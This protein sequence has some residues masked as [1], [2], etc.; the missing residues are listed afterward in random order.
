MKLKNLN[1]AKLYFLFM[2]VLFLAISVYT[3]ALQADFA[4]KWFMTLVV[5]IL[6]FNW[7]RIVNKIGKTYFYLL[8][9]A[10]SYLLTAFFDKKPFVVQ[11]NSTT[12]LILLLIFAIAFLYLT[13]S[14]KKKE[15]KT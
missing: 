9:F 13:L 2:S 5:S 14:Q 11:I 15:N 3:T 8:F 4:W 7:E 12:A 6:Y 1:S 10:T